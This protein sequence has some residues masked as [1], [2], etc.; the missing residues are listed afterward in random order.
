MEEETLNF[1]KQLNVYILLSLLE[2]DANI[3]A[4]APP[5]I[6][7]YMIALTEE[8]KTV[9][10]YLLLEDIKELINYSGAMS[11][12]LDKQKRS[13]WSCYATTN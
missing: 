12:R 13:S 4:M 11:D 8:D 10:A 9:L 6:I 3:S 5:E 2:K 1:N 7:T